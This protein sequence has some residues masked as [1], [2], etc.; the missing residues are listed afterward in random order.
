MIFPSPALL[1]QCGDFDLT[2]EYKA[3]HNEIRAAGE[4][5]L[6]RRGRVYQ[7]AKR[8]KIEIKAIDSAQAKQLR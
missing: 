3:V 6:G 8:K 1:S 4:T 7:E 5:F 2:I